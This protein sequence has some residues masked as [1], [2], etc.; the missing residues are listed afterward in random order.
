VKLGGVSLA[1]VALE[2]AG[3]IV[4]MTAL[5]RAFGLRPKLIQPARH[6]IVDLRCLGNHC[7]ERRD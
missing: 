5:G 2:L 1:C 4:L 6:R 3:S 7:R